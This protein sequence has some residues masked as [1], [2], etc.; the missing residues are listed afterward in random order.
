MIMLYHSAS[1]FAMF[2]NEGI[3]EAPRSPL[4]AQRPK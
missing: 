1:G 2:A 4:A 3:S